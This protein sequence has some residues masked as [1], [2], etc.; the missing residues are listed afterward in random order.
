MPHT[1]GKN[2]ENRYCSEEIREK[3]KIIQELISSIPGWSCRKFYSLYCTED[4][5]SD[6]EHEH[7]TCMERMKKQ[8]KTQQKKLKHLL[9]LINTFYL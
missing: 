4:L 1:V 8:I 7:K 9:P 2:G 3:Q 5:N 6:D